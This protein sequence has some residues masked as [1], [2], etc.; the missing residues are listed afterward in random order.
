MFLF[1]G[2]LSDLKILSSWLTHIAW[3]SNWKTRIKI[4]G[5]SRAMDHYKRWKKPVLPYWDDGYVHDHGQ[6]RSLRP[7]LDFAVSDRLDRFRFPG[8]SPG[9]RQPLVQ[10]K[11][12]FSWKRTSLHPTKDLSF[13]LRSSTGIKLKVGQKC[14]FLGRDKLWICWND[15]IPKSICCCFPT[16]TAPHGISWRQRH[17]CCRMLL[18]KRPLFC[19][20]KP[21]QK[22]KTLF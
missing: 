12:T 15:P 14:A 16:P 20:L 10:R 6:A 18:L 4:A 13:V 19:K 22:N 1:W 5:H 8:L 21:N 9:R 17:S 2:N 11:A 3:L 7:A